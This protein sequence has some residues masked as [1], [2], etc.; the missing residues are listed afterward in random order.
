MKKNVGLI[1]DSGYQIGGGHFWR[2]FN[3][4]KALKN[5]K[6]N[7]FFISNNLHLSFV[8]LLKKEKFNYIKINKIENVS[9]I[10]KVIK[11]KK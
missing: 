2:C 9:L 8:N 11:K 1:F 5:K 4:A 10:Q 6:K 7:F 3:L